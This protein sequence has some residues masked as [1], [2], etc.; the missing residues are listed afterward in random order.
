L[1]PIWNFSKAGIKG[2]EKIGDMVSRPEISSA[3]SLQFAA[4]GLKRDCVLKR[5]EISRS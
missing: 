4:I 3:I 1:V 2:I 5:A